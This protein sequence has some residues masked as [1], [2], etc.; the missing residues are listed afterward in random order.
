MTTVGYGDITPTNQNE[1]LFQ[2]LVLL[3]SCGFFSYS[4]G[5]VGSLIQ[6]I[7]NKDNDFQIEM[8]KLSQYFR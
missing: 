6:Q 2:V 1:A 4:F 3:L 7:A 5:L 8:M